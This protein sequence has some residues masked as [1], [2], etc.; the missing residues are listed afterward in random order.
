LCCGRCLGTR[1]CPLPR[2]SRGKEAR[3]ATTA[4]RLAVAPDLRRTRCHLALLLHAPMDCAE[5]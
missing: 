3:A 4:Q 5:V 1:R 2:R